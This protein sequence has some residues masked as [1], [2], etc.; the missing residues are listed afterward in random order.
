MRRTWQWITTLGLSL[1]LFA[2]GAA[3]AQ[4]PPGSAVIGNALLTLGVSSDAGLATG[5]TGL[6]FVPTRADGLAGVCACAGWTLVL[7]DAHLVESVEAFS[8]TPESASSIPRVQ[9]GAA[10]QLRVTHDFHPAPGSP[11]LYEIV[12]SVEN[13]GNV[14]VQPTYTRT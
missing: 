3:L 7:G 5:G 14:A 9:G 10:T 13:L 6:Q 1:A 12:V 11:N 4:T 2:P 8:F